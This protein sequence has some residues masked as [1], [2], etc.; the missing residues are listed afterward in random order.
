MNI[1][2]NVQVRVVGIFPQSN[3][4]NFFVKEHLKMSLWVVVKY[5]WIL[6][7][8]Y[9]TMEDSTKTDFLNTGVIWDTINIYNVAL[10][11]LFY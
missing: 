6:N 11:F 4:D 10:E 9:P 3:I 1:S 8:S 7:Y 5:T 2:H